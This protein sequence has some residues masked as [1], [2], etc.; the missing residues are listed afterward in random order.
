M[1]LPAACRCA[2]FVFGISACVAP[3]QDDDASPDPTPEPTPALDPLGEPFGILNLTLVADS[4][5]VDLSGAFGGFAEIDRETWSPGGYLGGFGTFG[6]YW[7]Y[8]IGGFPIP[9][10]GESRTDDL[11]SWLPYGPGDVA[12]WDGGPRITV[13]PFLAAALDIDD[14]GID[15][16]PPVRAYQVE[17]PLA[18]GAS[19]WLPSGSLAV[20]WE[21]GLDVAGLEAQVAVALPVAPE[22]L[23]PSVFSAARSRPLV[24]SWA[25][26]G[27]G[28]VTLSLLQGLG[29]V[30]T[31]SV[32]A[33]T[34]AAAVP[35]DALA[36]FQP[37]PVTLVVARNIEIPVAHPQG[38]VLLRVRAE[39]RIAG[40]ISADVAMEPSQA[41]RGESIAVQL[42]WWTGAFDG[43]T[44]V[45]LGEGITVTDLAALPGD[46]Q[47]ATA[48]VSVAEDAASGVRDLV[49]S[50]ATA[51]AAL[52][53]AFAVLDRLAPDTCEDA[54][55]EPPLPAGTTASTTAG[56]ANDFGAELDCLAWS[57]AGPDA[58]FRVEAD[59]GEAVEIALDAPGFDGALLVLADCA[60]PTT[61]LA[62]ADAGLEGEP[63]DL[64]FV[65]PDDGSYWV[66]VDAYTFGEVEPG[67][68]FTLTLNAGVP[69]TPGW[70]RPGESR[71]QVA[72]RREGWPPAVAAEDIDLGASVSSG[73]GA[74]A[75][76]V[77]GF[78][79]AAEPDAMPGPRELA[80][81][82]GAGTHQEA[83]ALY[84]T[85]LPSWDRCI[86][87]SSD[88][89]IAPGEWQAFA[90]RALSEIDAVACLDYPTEGPEV[91]LPIDVPADGFGTV[92]VVPEAGVDIQL[93]V[94]P[95][96]ADPNDC[97]AGVDAGYAGESET[98][99]QDSFPPG[100]SYLVIDRFGAAAGAET[101]GYT[102]Q[103]ALALP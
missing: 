43:T 55:V 46:P 9:P 64:A 58:V 50:S 62:C 5:Y 37:G 70:I 33:D 23:S 98:L 42:S 45:D 25:G 84:V 72:W 31:A 85:A 91:F 66:V 13:G 77:L 94:L 16:T 41:G 81:D 103:F 4:N 99:G 56:L 22:I 75:G 15:S 67:G 35:T 86:D 26:A 93:Y 8:D 52:P 20:A 11:A 3:P 48:T 27:E 97:P 39:S 30:F 12:W 54:S 21:G 53:A 24:V 76:S 14:D 19:A 83:Q 7:R 40:S 102:L 79:A 65:A 100:R 101:F 95:D 32:A 59:A 80:V 96:C 74:G 49:L 90:V 78:E 89:A 82:L 29:P 71:A 73:P 61:T 36:A 69:T 47:R 28:F 2:L 68:P 88:V 1:R 63:E 60:D 6:P 92:T 34:Q 87:A 44:T 51:T 10:V 17:D 18:P 57:L 38:T